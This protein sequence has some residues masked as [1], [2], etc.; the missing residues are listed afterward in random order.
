MIVHVLAHGEHAHDGSALIH[1]GPNAGR[2]MCSAGEPRKKTGA[3]PTASFFRKAALR[4][5]KFDEQRSA[6][7]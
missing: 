5:S 6:D 7:A 1:D 4:R 3:D 2:E